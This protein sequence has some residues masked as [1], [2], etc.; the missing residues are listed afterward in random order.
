VATSS[1]IDGRALR[2]KLRERVAALASDVDATRRDRGFMEAL[3]VMARFWRYSVF[4]QF[5]ILLQRA[6]KA[7]LE[8]SGLLATA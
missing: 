1:A 5:V 2:R 3:K 4:N 6:A 8:A 7:I